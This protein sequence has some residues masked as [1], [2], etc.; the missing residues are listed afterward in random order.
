MPIGLAIQR[1]S[2]KVSNITATKSVM[3]N[4][5]K[6]PGPPKSRPRR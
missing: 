4:T 2:G 3:G 1:V 5:K 6:A